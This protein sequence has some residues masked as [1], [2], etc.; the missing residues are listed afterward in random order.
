LA[1]VG[2][3]RHSPS[4]SARSI[5][6]AISASPS[7]RNGFGGIVIRMPW[8]E[9]ATAA[10]TS[11]RS[12]ASMN[13]SSSS[14]SR[15]LGSPADHSARRIGRCAFIVARARCRALLA[16]ATL[17]TG[18]RRVVRLLAPHLSLRSCTTQVLPSGS[19]K[20]ANEL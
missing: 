2:T 4:L 5:S 1:R 16:A 17:V 14:L 15:G 19:L 9:M 11:Q 18:E 8:A 13:R 20:S 6:G 3:R 7:N 12:C 10:A